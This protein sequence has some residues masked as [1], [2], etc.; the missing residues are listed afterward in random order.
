MIRLYRIPVL[1]KSNCF[2][3]RPDRVVLFRVAATLNGVY[4]GLVNPTFTGWKTVCPAKMDIAKCFVGL[5]LG[6]VT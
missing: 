4:Q 6:F 3:G 2:N 5:E 1:M